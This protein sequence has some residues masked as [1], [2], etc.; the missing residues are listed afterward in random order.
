MWM[1][2]RQ[3][4]GQGA[5]AVVLVAVAV[6]AAGAAGLGLGGDEPGARP[7]PSATPTATAVE[8]PDLS[9]VVGRRG[10][11]VPERVRSATA[12]KAQSKLWFQDGT[13]WGLLYDRR[14]GSTQIN[15]LDRQSRGWVSTGVVVDDRDHA[16]GDAL[17]DGH[18]LYVATGTTY[19][20]SWGAPPSAHDVRDGSALLKRFSYLPA[21]R[22]YRLDRGFPAL[23]HSGASESL[24]LDK[25]ST[26]KLW[27]TYTRLGKVFV[28]RTTGS[29][30]SWG[31]PFVLPGPG[32]RVNPDDT[33]AV[34]AFAGSEIG[35]FW[36]NQD[37]RAFY[38]A[39]HD[40]GAADH[41]WRTEVAYGLHAGGCARGCANDHMSVK[42]L[43]DG[44]V[45][46]AVKTANR[47]PGQPFIVLLVRSAAGW[48][49]HDVGTV[50][51]RTTRP[52]VVLDAQARRVY[53]FTVVPEEGGAVYYKRSDLDDISFGPGLGR[54]V[55][56]GGG[57]INNPTSTK[58]V[59]DSES[60]LLVLA[61]DNSTN[62]YW[63]D[64]VPV[65]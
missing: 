46:A 9:R 1:T 44:R 8:V 28:D 26:G 19:E 18:K 14:S 55:L 64:T 2:R 36:S 29:D 61:F 24:T 63:F 23:I 22:T 43:P 54:P 4:L 39:V 57:R 58:Q 49:T 32:T 7:R 62:H 12:D 52:L 17:W 65:G 59:V 41:A 15:R 51:E 47:K 3:R 42:A 56:S 48:A 53:L 33:S 60:G 38:F 20:S 31:R 34:V 35:V 25:D 13:W 37:T 27:V 30:T 10:P 6:A 5:V 40:D 11:A 45:F 50:E 16:R 21:Q